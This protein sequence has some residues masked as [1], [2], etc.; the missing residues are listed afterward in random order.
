[1]RVTNQYQMMLVIQ[2]ETNCTK[3]D[4]YE[5]D[6]NINGKLLYVIITTNKTTYE[7]NTRFGNV[8]QMKSIIN[9]Y[10]LERKFKLEN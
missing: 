7:Q 6:I 1:M 5:T 8:T 10:H 4:I 2:Y 3:I 9:T